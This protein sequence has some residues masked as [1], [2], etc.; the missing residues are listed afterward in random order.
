[1]VTRLEGVMDKMVRGSATLALW[2]WRFSTA[3]LVLLI[4]AYVLPA[5]AQTQIPAQG[6]DRLEWS[7]PTHRVNGDPLPVE[8]IGGYEVRVVYP[9]GTEE[10]VVV[11][12]SR[13]VGYELPNLP[14]GEYLFRIAA[15]DTDGLYSEFVDIA[16][17]AGPGSAP[18]A[19]SEFRFYEA[20]P[21]D[22][23]AG[24]GNCRV[25]TLTSTLIIRTE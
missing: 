25:L 5:Q 14:P 17:S 21:G 1:M 10:T 24:R 15:Y 18:E 4:V 16:P 11:P 8:Q 9:D 2:L 6:A 23:C 3:L 22:P 12:D 19:P 7:T 13:A 20:P